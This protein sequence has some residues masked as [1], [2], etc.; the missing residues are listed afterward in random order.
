MRKSGESTESIGIRTEDLAP[1][2]IK[3]QVQEI[4]ALEHTQLISR[5]IATA[6]A[7]TPIAFLMG[8]MVCLTPT[9]AF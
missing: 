3:K 8:E 2:H 5:E 4:E 9:S 1:A 6:I 7:I